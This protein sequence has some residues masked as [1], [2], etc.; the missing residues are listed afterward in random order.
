MS[1]SFTALTLTFFTLHIRLTQPGSG[2][3]PYSP[4]FLFPFPPS[5]VLCA[6]LSTP[7]S[8]PIMPT[9]ARSSKE[10][11]I[12]CLCTS[13]VPRPPPKVGKCKICGHRHS[14]HVDNPPGSSSKYLSRLLKNI[15]AT[16]VHEEARKETN[17]GFHP[18]QSSSSTVALP[19][20]VS[21]LPFTCSL[22]KN[23]FNN[24]LHLE[25]ARAR[26]RLLIVRQLAL[27]QART[28]QEL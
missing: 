22:N 18:Q 1:R 23:N 25:R 17:Q 12:P 15:D 20:I 5:I 3:P 27:P 21:T 9:C 26:E 8:I 24:Y 28:P 10:P 13:F 11:G 14:S 4:L 19:D 6:T 16:A 2:G 7:A